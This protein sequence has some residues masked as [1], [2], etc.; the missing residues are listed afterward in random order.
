MRTFLLRDDIDRTALTCRMVNSSQ[1][2]GSSIV[3][4]KSHDFMSSFLNQSLWLHDGLIQE[5]HSRFDNGH[6]DLSQRLFWN[7]QPAYES[8][9]VAF[10]LPY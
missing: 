10:S 3:R 5:I 7:G 1:L 9:S 2:H 4:L 8:Q 6:H